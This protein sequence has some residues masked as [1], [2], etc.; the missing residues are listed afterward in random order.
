M[1]RRSA[2]KK[3]GLA[4]SGGIL[5]SNLLSACEEDDGPSD[6]I[7]YEGTVVIVGAGAAG[8]YAANLLNSR[9][10]DVQIL[11]ASGQV[12]GRA[13]SLRGFDDFPIELGADIVY[14]NNS[15]WSGIINELG[16]GLVDT[17]GDFFDKFV[18]DNQVRD[19]SELSS[20]PG[21][22]NAQEFVNNIAQYRG[23]SQPISQ[24]IAEGDEALFSQIVEG[25][26]G[27]RYGSDITRL[28]YLGTAE[29][30]SLTQSGVGESVLSS[31][32][33]QDVLFSR[34]NAVLDKVQFETVV[35][36]ISYGGEEITLRTSGGD[37]TADKVIV[38]VPIS[39]LKNGTINFTPALPP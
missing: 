39:I 24:A 34:F 2:I 17:R 8:L 30:L 29:A 31:N 33:I 14:G 22:T 37:I 15:L 36:Q 13:R 18:F 35:E 5:L 9:G 23:P 12:G 28:D 32:P 1:K 20:L 38:T 7:D 27:N 16:L 19:I 21:F 6:L 10:I 4:T 11:E 25:Q 26:I 3:I